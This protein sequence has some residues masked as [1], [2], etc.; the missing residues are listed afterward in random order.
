MPPINPG[1]AAPSSALDAFQSGGSPSSGRDG[2]RQALEQVMGQ[3]KELKDKVDAVGASLPA[4]AP[5]VQQ[6]GQIL[7]RMIVKAAQQAPQQTSSS[8]AV[9]GGGSQ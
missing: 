4:F 1:S 6:I 9:P 2:Q 7:K 5:E 3:I 8:A